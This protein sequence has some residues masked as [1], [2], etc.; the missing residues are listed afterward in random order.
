MRSAGPLRVNGR[1]LVQ[2][3]DCRARGEGSVYAPPGD[4]AP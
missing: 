2:A 1:G 4:R 3:L